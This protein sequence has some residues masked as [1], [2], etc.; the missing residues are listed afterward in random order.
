MEEEAMFDKIEAYLLGQLNEADK[1]AFDQQI[2]ADKELAQE[3]QVQ[4]LLLEQVETLGALDMKERLQGIQQQV[5]KEEINHRRRYWIF[6]TAAAVLALLLYV[7][8]GP[9]LQNTS[10]EQIYASHYEP[11]QLSFGSR[12]GGNEQALIQAGSLYTQQRYEQALPLIEQLLES[13]PDNSRLLLAKGICYMESKDFGKALNTFQQL[14]DRNDS[15]YLQQALWYSA[16]AHLQLGNAIDA[17][18]LLE[19]MQG[20]TE[21]FKKK[22]S[23][24]ILEVM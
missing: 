17:R 21:N 3:V 22:E 12:A 11:Y 13:E 7:F 4:R 15:F 19:R 20:S 23:R 16:L 24:E 9:S 8:L 14:I 6:A 5:R 2:Q 1:T 10:T 18:K